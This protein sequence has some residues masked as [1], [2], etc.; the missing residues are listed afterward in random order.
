MHEQLRLNSAIVQAIQG[1]A[2]GFCQLLAQV[3]NPTLSDG[4]A[5]DGETTAR[6]VGALFAQ[7]H[8]DAVDGDLLACCKGG[9][10]Q[11]SLHEAG[12]GKTNS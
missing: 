3:G 12:I 10:T 7:Q 2:T 8:L 9:M 11:A 5:S 1:D 4:T 6:A